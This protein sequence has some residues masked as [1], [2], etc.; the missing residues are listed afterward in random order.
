[1]SRD[2]H[3][4]E[5]RP[6]SGG[7][8][9]V[10]AP[11]KSSSSLTVVAA[12]SLDDVVARLAARLD[13]ERSD[14]FE[15]DI[16]IVPNVGVREWLQRELSSRLGAG[17]AGIVANVKFLFVQQFLD[18]VI[19][20]PRDVDNWEIDRLTWFV[21]RAID[22]VGRGSIPGAVA[23]PL[24]VARAVADLFDRYA[25][26]RPSMLQYWLAGRPTDAVDPTRILPEHLR[27]QPD[28]YRRVCSLVAEP[29]PVQRLGQLAATPHEIRLVQDLPRRITLVGF[30]T[31]NAT[32][33]RVMT[34][35]AQVRDVE[36]HLLHP[37]RLS[38]RD[39]VAPAENLI[40]RD[41]DE[42]D[43][44]P[45][46]ARWGRPA[47]EARSVVTGTWTP[48]PAARNET[49][50]DLGRLR[51]SI[52]EDRPLVLSPIDE[53]SSALAHGDGSI[54]IH[55]CH[56]RV[57]Q[58]EVVRDALLHLVND[59][60]TLTLD[61]ISIQCADVVSFAP[62]ITSVFR[63]G[64]PVTADAVHPMDVTI[65]DQALVRE[66]P[67]EEAFWSL[68]RV[69]RSRCGLADVLGAVSLGPVREKFGLGD[70]ELARVQDWFESVAVR[71]G[72]DTEHR[73]QWNLPDSISQGTWDAALDRLFMGFATGAE[74]PRSG[75]GGVVPYDDISVTEAPLLA[76]MSEFVA[77]LADLMAAVSHDHSMEEWARILSDIVENF[78]SP[79]DERDL[80][81]R[82]LLDGLD[83]LATSSEAAQVP[84]SDAFA[85]DE[86]IGLLRDVTARIGSRPQTRT[87]AITVSGLLAQ[88]GVP[89]RVIALL[90]VSHEMFSAMG[91]SGD[92]VLSVHPCLGD[93]MPTASGRLQLLG[94]ILSARDHLIITCEG[95]DITT[96]TTLPLPVPVQE[97]LEATATVLDGRGRSPILVRHPRQAHGEDNFIAGLVHADRP[98]T[99]D[100]VAARAHELRQEEPRPIMAGRSSVAGRA[101]DHIS[102]DDLR[103]VLVKPMEFFTRRILGVKLPDIDI[104]SRPD[105]VEFWPSPLLY[106]Q[107]GRRLMDGATRGFE[108]MSVA[109]ERLTREAPLLGVFPPGA[110]GHASMQRLIED[111]IDM[112]SHVPPEARDIGSHRSIEVDAH[113]LR[114]GASLNGT[115]DHIVDSTLIRT[116]FVRFHEG[117][118]LGPWVDLAAATM[119]DPDAPWSVHFVARGPKDDVMTRSL[120]LAGETSHER[121]ET[122]KEVID[123][124]RTLIDAF[125]RGRLPYLPKTSARMVRKEPEECRRI[126]DEEMAQSKVARFV[127]DETPWDDFMAE[128]P[129]DGDPI[130]GDGSPSRALQIATFI[131]SHVDA[132]IVSLQD[133][134]DNEGSDD[135]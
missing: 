10:S 46:T 134:E 95:A 93:P 66:D 6:V 72:I 103:E 59:D 55:A 77:L 102:L 132:T 131:W 54:Q 45:L 120:R 105:V 53:E 121:L 75:P 33:R 110:L 32:V 126:F 88:Q 22:D 14:P 123:T 79:T 42:R 28:V 107:I 2:E 89:Y 56:G 7:K 81:C 49:P 25:V 127:Y 98:F 69:A 16:V 86:V 5:P 87:G 31:V 80:G 115:I 61:D 135:E 118:L 36:I 82:R 76:T 60:P 119:V 11:D 94:A 116:M 26:H 68:L 15:S 111:V 8:I 130:V 101:T 47:V 65:S 21:H 58:V 63:S 52:H 108:D 97:M 29:G 112:L 9:P 27:W 51:S 57:R 117:L 34:A 19:G 133:A 44:N 23:R 39:V 124:A 1:M 35:L 17:R 99:F 24:T 128:S 67:F 50:T 78:F 125:S 40:A 12:P 90:G 104:D 74:S 109:Q 13:E 37:C 71:F 96:N 38:G 84:V 129:L 83:L 30:V 92:D 73:R 91:A 106:A 3:S 41:H 64:E 113:V 18:L 122:A 62:I 4:G 114:D 48:A 70:D 85:F 43:G 100:P 20:A